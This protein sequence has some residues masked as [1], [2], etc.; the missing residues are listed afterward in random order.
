MVTIRLNANG[1]LEELD[2]L[3]SPARSQTTAGRAL[4]GQPADWSSLL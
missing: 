2:A 1:R 4:A 3:P